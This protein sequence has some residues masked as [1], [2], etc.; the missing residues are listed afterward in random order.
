VRT[1]QAFLGRLIVLR[2][3]TEERRLRGLQEDLTDAVIHDLRGPLT[4][5]TGALGMIEAELS[6]GSRDWSE[7][8]VRGAERML[9]MI[10]SLLEI[11]RLEQGALPLQR[12]PLCLSRAVAEAIDGRRPMADRKGVRLEAEATAALP[13]AFADPALVARVLD[14]LVA[15]AVR[16]TPAGGAVRVG[17]EVLDDGLGVT[18]RDSGPGILPELKARLFEKFVTGDR[19]GNG[20]GLAFCRLVVEAQGGRIWAESRPGHGAAFTFTLP[21]VGRDPRGA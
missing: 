9:A 21:E 6:P 10:D 3:V 7:R 17:V 5:I 14:N 4:S 16:F 12:R 15:N 8:A 18:V 1:D 2:D 19:S 11:S 20:L 13:E